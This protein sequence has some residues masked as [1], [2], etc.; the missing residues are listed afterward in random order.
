MKN[1]GHQIDSVQSH[2]YLGIEKDDT[3]IWHSLIDHLVIKMSGSL[4]VCEQNL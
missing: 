3:L 4:V 1:N 2:G